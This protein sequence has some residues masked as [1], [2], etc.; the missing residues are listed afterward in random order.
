ML[1]VCI[2][3]FLIPLFIKQPLRLIVWPLCRGLNPQV[4]NQWTEQ[5]IKLL[6]KSIFLPVLCYYDYWK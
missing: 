6:K 4:A 2:F 5:S 1:Y 3:F